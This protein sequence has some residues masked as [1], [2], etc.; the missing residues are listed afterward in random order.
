MNSLLG[1]GVMDDERG[2]ARH[3]LVEESGDLVGVVPQVFGVQGAAR[4]D[5]AGDRRLRERTGGLERDRR[6]RFAHA[7][8]IAKNRALGGFYRVSVRRTSN[9]PS[10]SRTS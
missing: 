7:R 8:S 10:A 1:S 6:D 9:F 4:L 2:L 5:L 3:A